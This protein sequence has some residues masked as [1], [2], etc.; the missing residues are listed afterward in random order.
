MASR[1]ISRIG[2][3]TVVSG[4]S[5][6]CAMKRSSKPT[7]E[8][9][10]GTRRP[11]RANLAHGA[12]RGHVVV[13]EDG[14]GRIG[15]APSSGPW[16]SMPPSGLPSPWTTNSGRNGM[17]ASSSACAVAAEALGVGLVAEAVADVGDAA[18]AQFDQVM[19]GLEAGLEVV[20]HDGVDEFAGVL[21][22]EQDDGHLH[23][24]KH[25]H[26]EGADARGGDDDAVDAALLEGAD[27]AHFAL[28]IGVGVGEE[29]GVAVVRWR[30]PR[31]RRRLRRQ[32]GRRW[33]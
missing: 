3:R 27:H 13:A 20:D 2:W 30:R 16:P 10:S 24:G 29:D 4:G 15:A 11:A 1:P 32:T 23:L 31:C 21:V 12:E 19:R 26:V 5:V 7:T 14:G 9:S 25:R 17:S 18:M 33:W 6:Y 8:M 28:G 22:V